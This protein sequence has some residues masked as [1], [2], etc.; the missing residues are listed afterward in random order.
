MKDSAIS[1]V[2]ERWRSIRPEIEKASRQ[3]WSEPELPLMEYK[4]ADYLSKWLLRHGFEVEKNAG[5]LPTAFVASYGTADSP[6]IGLLAEYDAMPGLGNE[7]VP[8][9]QPT[10]QTAGHGCGHNQIGAANIGAAIAA[11]YAVE[12]LELKGRVVVV[13]CPAEEIIFGKVVLLDKGIFKGLD[14]ILTSHSDFQNGIM[15]RPCQSVIHGE[16]I[17]SGVSAH[18]GAPR[19]HNALEAAELAVQSFERL[20]GHQFPDASVEHILR[21]AGAMPNITP[22]ESRLWVYTRHENYD[23]AG[24]VYEL[25]R[26]AA[27]AAAKLTDTGFSEQFV[28]ATRG[29]LPN[30]VLAEVLFR[31]IKIIGPPQWSDEN[32]KW[33]RQLSQHC[34]PNEPFELDREV[35]LY[36]EGVD[37]YGQDDGEVSWHIPLG[38]INWAIPLQVPLHNWATTALSGSA[39]GN[40]GPLMAS[41]TLV[42][43]TVELLSNPSILERS[44]RELEQRRRNQTPSGPRY[45]GFRT[46]TTHPEM[47]WNATWRED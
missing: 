45:A 11:R 18:T 44:M 36:T 16:F 24:I 21:R 34:R 20:R 14:A 46:F 26:D 43:T 13:G 9:Y 41:E 47:F 6:V 1:R 37:P 4:A 8:Q 19:N 31:N 22:D 23:R 35:Y 28:A 25:I 7:A 29:Y 15:S 40:P 12:E 5:G 17:F 2:R 39:A 30:D 42:L 27:Q 38:R 32:L 33:M 3:L 10:G